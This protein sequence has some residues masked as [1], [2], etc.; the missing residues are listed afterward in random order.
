MDAKH[1]LVLTWLSAQ[2]GELQS[3]IDTPDGNT[4]SG[5]GLSTVG[6][7][8]LFSNPHVSASE[9]LSLLPSRWQASQLWRAYLNNV[10]GLVKLLHVPSVQPTVFAAINNPQ[11]TAPDMNALLFAIYFAAVTS[12]RWTEV[13][14]ILGQDRQAALNT[15]QRGLELSLHAK[16]FLDSPT[17][18]SLQAVALYLVTD[19]L[20]T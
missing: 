20:S 12:L 13:Q 14:S 18:L 11:D 8:G 5:G 15:Y 9:I 17:I 19:L 2:Q 6:F 7:D 4:G 16:S 3:A 10:D 1:D